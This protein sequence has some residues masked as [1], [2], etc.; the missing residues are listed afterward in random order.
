MSAVC[1]QGPSADDTVA[2]QLKGFA[3]QARSPWQRRPEPLHV[4]HAFPVQTRILLGGKRLPR[5]Q[6]GDDSGRQVDRGADRGHIE[7][8]PLKVIQ[9]AT[10]LFGADR[11]FAHTA[12][13]PIMCMIP[14][15]Y[16][17]L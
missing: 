8:D 17:L 2:H 9:E 6:S 12:G 5:V 10:K 15:V 11:N 3:A 1:A 4:P 7:A 16:A 14:A 13:R